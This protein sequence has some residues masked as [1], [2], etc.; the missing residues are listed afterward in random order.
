MQVF[1]IDM[2]FVR[3][4]AKITPRAHT[5]S[6]AENVKRQ[7]QS[8][9]ELET[10]IKAD[11]WQKSRLYFTENNPELTQNTWTQFSDTISWRWVSMGTATQ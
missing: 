11:M 1:S 9:V 8:T 3:E 4:N 2:S 6:Q 10:R 7:E 5:Q